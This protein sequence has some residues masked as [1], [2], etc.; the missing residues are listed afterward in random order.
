MFE[1]DFARLCLN[2]GILVQSICN[3]INVAIQMITIASFS[4]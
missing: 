2:L 4:V 1:E 3:Y